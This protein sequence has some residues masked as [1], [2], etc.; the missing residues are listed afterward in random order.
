MELSTAI[1]ATSQSKLFCMFVDMYRCD[2]G[3]HRMLPSLAVWQ[4][5]YSLLATTAAFCPDC[6]LLRTL[7]LLLR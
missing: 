5:L 3:A 2:S 7:C 6:V 1:T 4:R